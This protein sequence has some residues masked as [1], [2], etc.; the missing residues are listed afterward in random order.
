MWIQ[1]LQ[2]GGVSVQEPMH[3]IDANL[4]QGTRG[5]SE[6]IKETSIGSRQSLLRLHLRS[7]SP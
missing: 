1:R 7:M 4:L 3:R 6:S 2:P 5:M